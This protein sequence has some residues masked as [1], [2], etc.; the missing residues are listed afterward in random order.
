MRDSG[1]TTLHPTLWRTCRVLANRTRLR[2]LHELFR[3]PDRSVSDVAERVNVPLPL[4]SR[5][6]RQLNARGLLRAR[7]EGKW[8]Y[9]R[10]S[11]DKSIAAAAPLLRALEQTF[12]T[13]KQPVEVIFRQVTA[14]THPQRIAIVQA[15]QG[16]RLNKA[17]LRIRTGM[18]Q[19]AFARH[20]KK[21]VDRGFVVVHGFTCR[22]GRPRKGL[23]R[24]LQDLTRRA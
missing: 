15:L 21:L 8:V 16:Y 11:A 19:D 20:L 9:Y 10:P 13:E 18:S 5:C 4:A 23:G 6:L 17:E 22:C 2:L 24:T 12:A 14:L 3:H 1:F 7:R